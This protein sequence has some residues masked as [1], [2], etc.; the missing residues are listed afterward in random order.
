[1]NESHFGGEV[2][3]LRLRALAGADVIG[4]PRSHGSNTLGGSEAAG[5][6]IRHLS[7]EHAARE[8]KVPWS[9]RIGRVLGLDTHRHTAQL[10][11]IGDR[12]RVLAR[13]VEANGTERLRPRVERPTEA[14]IA[15]LEPD[16]QSR[17]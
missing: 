1:M 3:V 6:T 12:P 9:A 15:G 13:I 11:T 4:A 17:G 5:S 16:P 2:Q 10:Q 7:H 8:A 14:Q